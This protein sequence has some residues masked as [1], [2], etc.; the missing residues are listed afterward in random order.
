MM[1][2]FGA[3][4][5][6]YEKQ[7]ELKVS[8]IR[9]LSSSE[10]NDIYLVNLEHIVR[11]VKPSPIDEPFYTQFGEYH[12]YKTLSDSSLNGPLLPLFYYSP[13]TQNKIEVY[14]DGSEPFHDEKTLEA[15]ALSIVESIAKL[16]ELPINDG[17]F[18]PISRY[19]SY[20]KASHKKLPSQY[21]KDLISRVTNIID[22]R[23]KVYC[24]HRLSKENLC[25]NQT[26]GALLLDFKFGGLNASIFDIASLCEENGFPSS[27][28]RKC[29][30]HYASLTLESPYTYEE[31]S[32]V[33]CFLD[34][35]WFYYYSAKA[36][37][38]GDS[39][40]GDKA[41][42]RRSRFLFSFE[43]KLMEDAGDE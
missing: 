21:E 14:C 43:G 2:T 37:L 22:S 8:T 18:D 6:L 28:A 5:E 24:H 9:L 33:I 15:E 39:S 19:M 20:K 32:D 16:H 29:L 23:K 10:W 7:S 25:L 41:K 40:Y 3:A 31:L 12:L 1:D 34:G 35:M 30:N 27:L 13:N 11:I 17:S 26:Y 36:L 4:I 38:T 42:Q